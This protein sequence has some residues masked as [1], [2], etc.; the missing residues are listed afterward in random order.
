MK[1]GFDW[2]IWVFLVWCVGKVGWGRGLLGRDGVWGKRDGKGV[3][4]RFVVAEGEG[5]RKRKGKENGKGRKMEREGLC[6]N[7]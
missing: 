5:K 1:G 4:V 3:V 6:R 7:L 2:A